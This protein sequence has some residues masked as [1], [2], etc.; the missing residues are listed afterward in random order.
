MNRSLLEQM[1]VFAYEKSKEF[2]ADKIWE[3]LKCFLIEE[4]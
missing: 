3:Q 2:H 1:K 4:K